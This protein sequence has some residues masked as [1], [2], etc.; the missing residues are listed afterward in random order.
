MRRGD[1][2]DE[3]TRRTRQDIMKDTE[4]RPKGKNEL[5]EQPIELRSAGQTHEDTTQSTHRLKAAFVLVQ[6]LVADFRTNEAH[7]LSPAYQEQEVRN[8]FINKFFMALG[9]DVNHDE[10]K[11]PFAQEVKVERS[12]STCASQ[13]R[14]DYAFYI[15]PNFQDVR[16]FVEAKKPF[17][18][19]ATADNYFQTIRYGWNAQTRL[20][21]LTD[22]EQFQILDCRYKPNIDTALA[23]C[24]S[25]YHCGHYTDIEKFAE[26]WYLFSREAVADGA[27]EKFTETLPKKRGKAVQRGLFRGGYQSID[28]AFLEELDEHRDT[29][30]RA[31]KNRNPGL[32]GEALTEITQRTLDRLVFIRFLEDKSIQPEQLVA[33]FGDKGTAWQDFVAAS[34]RLDGIY[35]GIVFKKHDIIDAPGFMADDRPFVDICEEMSHVNTA[36]DF[37]AIP[38]HIL[39]SIYERFL[40]KVIVTTPKRARVEEKPE[41]RKAGGVYYTPDYIVRYIVENTVGKLI[42]DKTPAR[43]AGMRFAD[44]ACGSGSFLLGV[45]DVLLRH[46]R[47]WFNAHPGK[48]KKA[49]CVLRDNG[50]WHLS[51][52]QRRNIL[53]NNIYGSDIDHQAVEVAQLSLY[54]RLL[55][56]ETTATA[57]EYQLEFHETLL[58]PLNKNIVCGNSLVGTDIL[59]GQL[60]EPTEERKLN[61]MDFQDRFPEIMKRGGFDAIVGN[62]P[63]GAEFNE[64]CKRY[65]DEHYRLNTGKYESYILF[66]ERQS[67]LLVDGGHLGVIIPSYWI[68]R[69]Q[70]E[71]LRNHFLRKLMPNSLLVLPENVFKG[72]RMDSC[73]LTASLGSKVETVR[74]AE[75]SQNDLR[76]YKDVA[77]LTKRLRDVPISAWRTVKR[78]AFNPRITACD[79]PIIQ[80]VETGRTPLGEFVDITQGLTL[81]RLSTLTK[82]FGA[83]RAK[84]IVKKRLFHANYKKDKTYKKELLGR[85][86]ARF[87][88]NWNS[89]SWVSYGPWLAHAVD[90]R[91]FH[92][93]R[94]VIQKLR[95]PMLRQRLVAGFIDDN[96]TYSAGVLLNAIPKKNSPD[97][98]F[99]LGLINSTLVNYWYRKRILDVSIRVADLAEV[100]IA[101]ADNQPHERLV[102]LV[103]QML[104]AK[105]QLAATRTDAEKDF[106]QNK[107]AGLDRQIDA[108]VYELYALTESEIAVVESAG[109]CNT[110]KK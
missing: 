104:Q 85:D 79:L 98:F 88:V 62:P 57:H 45:Y 21:V 35:N 6:K 16:F 49:G 90:E 74:V 80:K 50:A 36:Y 20:A 92:G 102:A 28:D 39:G 86:V 63:W 96:E 100:P 105:K 60:F 83:E 51:L 61:P 59:T 23:H 65:F 37:N 29:L 30:A 87:E 43:I 9:W 76:S 54:L 108:L 47:D 27:L 31:F 42:E 19:I 75:I 5:K 109:M 84:E 82:K 81:Y 94:L 1:G 25:K 44:I 93:P 97:L 41:V 26:I 18:E 107:C 55:E 73:I 53:L 68:S 7:Y 91:F 15:A 3:C 2:A 72:V 24:I 48:A 77:A 101:K 17:G 10:Q 103:R 14:A 58:P 38:I 46:H 64:R 71:G 95:N 89:Q 66:I 32:D 11:N 52:K 33:N 56:E 4:E 8:D 99:L 110:S 67:R 106:Y 70:T 13:R 78:A 40:G 69:S 22:F 12:V 34:R